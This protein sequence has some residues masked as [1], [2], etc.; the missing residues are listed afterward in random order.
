MVNDSP[1]GRF[2][3]NASRCSVS[4]VEPSA[5][6]PNAT[7][8]T[9]GKAAASGIRSPVAGSTMAHS[10]MTLKSSAVSCGRGST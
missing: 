2:S 1:E 7:N 5:T 10:P 4:A 6:A 9:S 3:P 8:T